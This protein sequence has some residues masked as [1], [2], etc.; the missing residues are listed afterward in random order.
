MA[1]ISQIRTGLKTRL[2]TISGLR[3][4]E[5]VTHQVN[6]PQAIIGNIRRPFHQTFGSPGDSHVTVDVIVLA[7][8]PDKDLKRGQASLDAYCDAEGDNS[9]LDAIEKDCT[10]GG[11]VD[12][13]EVKS[14]DQGMIEFNDEKYIGATFTVEVYT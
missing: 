8:K 6:L 5:Y 7:G 1:T 4:S 12:D 9:I 11:V 14:C 2:E 3:V 10:L 13:L